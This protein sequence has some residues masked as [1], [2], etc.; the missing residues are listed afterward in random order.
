MKTALM[1][2]SYDPMTVGHADAVRRAAGL[3]DRVVV[4]VMNNAQK[5][6]CFSPEERLAIARLTLAD[7]PNCE[8]IFSASTLI[9]LFEEVGADCVVKGVRDEKDFT[10]EQ[11]QA[12]WNRAHDPRAE[13]LYLPADPNYVTLS[14][15]KVRELLRAGTLPEDLLAPAAADYLRTRGWGG[16]GEPP[17]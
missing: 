10:Y 16:Q 5:T 7:I 4:A 3:F 6:Y 17:R 9:V 2:G 15:T 12:L 13:T 1:P 11:T 8:V 14:S